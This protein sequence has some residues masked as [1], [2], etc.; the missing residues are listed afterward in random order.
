MP[1]WADLR[2]AR[3]GPGERIR[4]DGVGGETNLLTKEL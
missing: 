1:I 4:L 3:R 2:D